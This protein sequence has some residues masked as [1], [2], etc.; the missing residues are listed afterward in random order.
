MYVFVGVEVCV[1]G[2]VGVYVCV[3][4]RE[5]DLGVFVCGGWVCVCRKVCVYVY[6]CGRIVCFIARVCLLKSL[7]VCG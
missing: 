3:G 2:S 6:K 4:E 5:R 7:F 1:G